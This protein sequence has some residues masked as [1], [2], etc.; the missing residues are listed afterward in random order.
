MNNH[1]EFDAYAE[2]YSRLDR[3]A[4]LRPSWVT[5]SAFREVGLEVIARRFILF[6]PRALDRR[7]QQLSRWLNRIPFGAQ[8]LVVGRKPNAA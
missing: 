3:D 5:A 6:A 8:Y 1:S 7:L 2:N 4:H